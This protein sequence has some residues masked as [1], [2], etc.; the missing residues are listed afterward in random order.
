MNTSCQFDQK[1]ITIHT[2][3]SS[4]K[5]KMKLVIV[6]IH[7]NYKQKANKKEICF[8]YLNECSES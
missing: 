8:D 7:G 3:K 2:L 4:K 1:D 6:L 5:K